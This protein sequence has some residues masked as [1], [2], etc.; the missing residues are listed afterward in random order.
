MPKPKRNAWMAFY[1]GDYLRDTSRLTTEQ[2]GAYLLLIIDYFVNGS[3]PDD[4]GVLANITKLSPQA[5]K[6]TR[7]VLLIYFSIENGRWTHKRVE[8]E[9]MKAFAVTEIRRSAGKGGANKRWGKRIANAIAEPPEKPW[10]NDA[11]SQSPRITT[12]ET[13]SAR[14]AAC[15]A[16]A[17]QP[18]REASGLK[19]PTDTTSEIIRRTLEA[20]A[21]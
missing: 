6:K 13:V 14:E 3:L 19:K 7:P 11:Q 17:P 20:A 1:P 8:A 5:W 21:K 10:Q 2:H 15:V 12:T 9:R 18:R 4:D 16:G